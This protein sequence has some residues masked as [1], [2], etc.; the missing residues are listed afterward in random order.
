MT[1]PGAELPITGSIQ[2]GRGPFSRVHATSS[3][4]LEVMM[5]EASPGLGPQATMPWPTV[6][7]CWP[8]AQGAAGFAE[9][10]EEN[11]QGD[12]A[13]DVVWRVEEEACFRWNLLLQRHKPFFGWKQALPPGLARPRLPALELC[14][15]CAIVRIQLPKA[16]RHS[17]AVWEERERQAGRR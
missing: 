13:C 2:A 11:L 6:R 14:C 15:C 9:L 17:C 7:L 3:G 12:G 5:G 1:D 8:G 4:K 10:W 16:P